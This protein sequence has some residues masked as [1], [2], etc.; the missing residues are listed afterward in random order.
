MIH[1][2]NNLRFIAIIPARWASSRFPGKPLADL[3]GMTV[4][5]RVCRRVS[6]A[7]SDVYVA[8]DDTRIYDA[9]TQFGGEATAAAPTGALRPLRNWWPKGKPPLT[10]P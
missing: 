8:T 10:T 2:E 4:I 1:M 3:A 6:E 7:V 5:E 9:V